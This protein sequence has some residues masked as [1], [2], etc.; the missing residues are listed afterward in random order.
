MI[1]CFDASLYNKKGKFKIRDHKAT[2][3]E[4]FE[5]IFH[6]WVRIFVTYN[7]ENLKEIFTKRTIPVDWSSSSSDS[8]EYYSSD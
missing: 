1:D 3:E 2:K 7:G 6:D 8:S 4:F 5:K